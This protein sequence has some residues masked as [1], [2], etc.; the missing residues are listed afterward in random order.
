MQY[1]TESGD[2]KPLHYDSLVFDFYTSDRIYWFDKDGKNYGGGTS[3]RIVRLF[4]TKVPTPI[5]AMHKDGSIPDSIETAD[6]EKIEQFIEQNKD[7]LQLD[8]LVF[9]NQDAMKSPFYFGNNLIYKCSHKHTVKHGDEFYFY[10]I[11][12]LKN[13]CIVGNFRLKVLGR[14]KYGQKHGEWIEYDKSGK[15]TSIKKY[16]RDRLV[17]ETYM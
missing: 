1:R 14:W 15:I 10:S 13:I 4:T 5:G 7:T 17:K 16:K 12:E 8:T 3:A 9:I 2:L 6:F 11:P